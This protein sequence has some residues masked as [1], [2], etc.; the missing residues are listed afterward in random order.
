MG[1]I[2]EQ[3]LIS[4]SENRGSRNIFSLIY[5]TYLLPFIFQL[6]IS[7]GIAN[8]DGLRGLNS[9][10]GHLVLKLI[11]LLYKHRCNNHLIGKLKLVQLGRKSG[12]YVDY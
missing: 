6:H 3:Q 8:Y 11:G 7:Y 5:P 1:Y 2:R 9:Y 10:Q 4:L 12:H